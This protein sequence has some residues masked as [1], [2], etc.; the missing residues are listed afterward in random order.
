MG[1]LFTLPFA[2]GNEVFSIFGKRDCNGD[3]KWD[4]AKHGGWDV[5]PPKVGGVVPT[6]QGQAVCS[7]RVD[8]KNVYNAITQDNG[9]NS[10]G[11]AIRIVTEGGVRAYMAHL[12]SHNLSVG[13][14]VNAGDIVGQYG[15]RT[16]G[17]SGGVHCHVEFRIGGTSTSRRTC[18]G[19]MFGLTNTKDVVYNRERMEAATIGWLDCTRDNYRWRFGPGVENDLFEDVNNGALQYCIKGVLYRVYAMAKDKDGQSWY[20]ITPG[21][22]CITK[23][24][25]PACW[26]SGECGTYTAKKPA[27]AA[28]NIKEAAEGLH[29]MKY[30]PASETAAEAL[31]RA[32]LALRLPVYAAVS[33]GDAANLKL[34]A[35]S[36]KM[37]VEEV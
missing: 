13:E 23:G 37:T 12:Y 18:P 22:A 28:E 8:W 30:T 3:G 5:R 24:T 15:P 14:F 7:G 25:A 19:N 2:G 31:A 21:D 1:E 32:M 34:V 27:S 20:Q 26:V 36:H 11:N 16:T 17:N 10:Y 35:D 29:V 33:A 6:K 4:T 9:T